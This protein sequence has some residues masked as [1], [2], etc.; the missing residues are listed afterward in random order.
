MQGTLDLMVYGREAPPV[1][2]SRV[3]DEERLEASAGD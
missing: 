1:T 3:E 2:Q